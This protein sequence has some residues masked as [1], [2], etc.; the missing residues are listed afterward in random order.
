MV[1]RK[2]LTIGYADLETEHH[3]DL[4]SKGIHVSIEGNGLVDQYGNVPTVGIKCCGLIVKS[5]DGTVRELML[6]TIKEFLTA[7]VDN[8][9]DRCYFH[10]LKFD[11]SFIASYMKN[12]AIALE[13]G[14]TVQCKSRLIND[15]G[16]VYSD[17][18][19]YTGKRNKRTHRDGHRCELWDSAKVWTSSLRSLGESFGVYKKG[20]GHEEAL[21]IGCDE[22]MEEYCLQD[23]RVMMTAMEYYFE[24][25][26]EE[27]E[28]T[29]PYGWMTAGSTAYHLCMM[30]VKK[31]MTSNDFKDAFPACNLKNGFPP[32]LREGF[33]GA[34]PLLDPAIRNVPLHDVKVF[35]I[36]SQYPDKLRNYPM[37]IGRP[38]KIREL[39]MD[40][41]MKLKSEGRLWTAK[42][43]M[44][45]DVKPG[46]RATYLLKR[47][48]ID[49]DTLC[50]H[51]NDIDGMFEDKESFQVVTS[52]DMDY[53][54]RDYDIRYIEVLDAVGFRTDLDHVI[55]PFI[56]KWYQ[57]K[58]EASARKD[59]PMK[60][61]A[62]LILNALYGKFGT[63]PEHISAEYAFEGIDG[64]MIRVRETEIVDV[65]KHP[66]YL[67]IAMFTTC[68]ARD[69]ISKTCNEIG[70]EH[71]AYTDTDSVHIHGLDNEECYSRIK[72]A[73]YNIHPTD[74]GAYDYE[75]RWGDALYVRNKG[76]YH[77]NEMDVHT[78]EILG[79]SEI[80]MA[81]ANGFD[82]FDCLNDVVNKELKGVQTRGYRVNGGILL[83]EKEVTIDTRMDACIK[84]RRRMKGMNHE[85]S[86]VKRKEIEDSIW[87]SYGVI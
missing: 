81:G 7:L 18:L 8:D 36:N 2:A 17:V 71:V 86:V 13:N 87:E 28:G 24:R 65:D 4:E 46:H 22:R 56:D 49:D 50:W 57:I 78:G 42:I 64:N 85:Q 82:G 9:V 5:P 19:E 67:P 14:W 63:N 10:N 25:C 45:A 48:G 37:P 69:V 59:E 70:W 39:T 76:Y 20:E 6:H 77:F 84:S 68:Y 47:K 11:D 55:A 61:F 60:A 43:K 73:G 41:L 21:R 72:K 32:W 31:N 15:R 40:N 53:I 74:L 23:C 52:V 38:I 27:S 26:K 66:L 83:M 33:K 30:H 35:D 3:L 16:A 62:K 54:L 34:V 58:E 44:I 12:D 79:G 29:R 80:K 75:S 1:R 51:I